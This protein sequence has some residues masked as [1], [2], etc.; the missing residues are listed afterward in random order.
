MAEEGTY[1]AAECIVS[2]GAC[3]WGS[4]KD[5]LE[6]APP[7]DV[8]KDVGQ[9]GM[10]SDMGPAFRDNLARLNLLASRHQILV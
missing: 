9:D 1:I 7:A 5:S 8:R 4:G 6:V 2:D 10:S 3:G